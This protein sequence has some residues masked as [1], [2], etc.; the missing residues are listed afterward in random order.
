[1]GS[2]WELNR[3]TA[4]K[5][6]KAA[7]PAEHLT[8]LPGLVVGFV[9]RKGKQQWS[10][11]AIMDAVP[12]NHARNVPRLGMRVRCEI[13]RVATHSFPDGGLAFYARSVT[14]L[15]RAPPPHVGGYACQCS[16]GENL[17]VKLFVIPQPRKV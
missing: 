6:S 3:E 1:V 17:R 13:P 2:T 10:D 9:S 5:I 14:P 7:T 11:P 12:G 16:G 8:Y 15:L 4:G